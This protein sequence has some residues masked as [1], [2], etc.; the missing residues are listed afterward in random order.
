MQKNGQHINEFVLKF[1][2]LGLFIFVFT[3]INQSSYGSK[4]ETSDVYVSCLIANVWTQAIESIPNI[5]PDF[6]ENWLISEDNFLQN[7]LNYSFL[8]KHL[9]NQDQ[10]AYKFQ[11]ELDDKLKSKRWIQSG[12]HPHLKEAKNTPSLA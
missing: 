8:Q 9:T 11:S 7:A 2:I 1:L 12:I 5:T 10:L 6:N 4:H 3:A